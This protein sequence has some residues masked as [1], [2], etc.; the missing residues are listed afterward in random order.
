MKKSLVNTIW[1]V[2]GIA[3]V[4]FCL[5]AC[6]REL[7]IQ[8]AYDFSLEVMPVQ[9][10]IAKGETAEMRCSLKRAGR[11]ANTQSITSSLMARVA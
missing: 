5:S 3:L 2:G 4:L 1:A 9:N 11:F 7:D 8:Q 10:S 6:T